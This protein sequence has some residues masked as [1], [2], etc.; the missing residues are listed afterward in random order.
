MDLQHGAPVR[1]L[2]WIIITPNS[3]GFIVL[4]YQKLLVG[5]FNHL[6]KYESQWEGLSHILNILW[7]IKHIPNHQPDYLKL[8]RCLFNSKTYISSLTN[9]INLMKSMSLL[10]QLG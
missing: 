6:E 2:S 8:I 4:T 5:G 7:K 3:L 10:G 1:Y 9:S